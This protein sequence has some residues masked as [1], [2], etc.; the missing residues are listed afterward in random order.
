MWCTPLIPVLGRQRQLDL[1]EFKANLVYRASSRTARAI[2]RNI[3]SKNKTKQNKTKQ[4]DHIASK[5]KV[6]KSETSANGQG[7]SL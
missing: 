6:K 4:M 2:Q 3:V 7:V 1:Y 5:L